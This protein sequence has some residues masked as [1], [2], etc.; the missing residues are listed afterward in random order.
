MQV[1][2]HMVELSQ[3]QVARVAGIL[4]L[5]IIIAGI[6][7][8]FFVRS[9]LIV[10]GDAMATANKVLASEGLFR[11]SIAADLVMIM[12]DVA[13]AV[14]FYVLLKPVSRSLSLLAAFFRLAQAANLGINALNLFFGLQLLH[15]AGDVAA[16]SVDQLHDLALFF[17]NAHGVGYTISLVFFGFSILILG[18]LI[19]KSGYLPRIL[20]ILLIIASLGYLLDGFANVLLINYADYA[21]ILGAVVFGPALIAELTVALWLLI[22]G[23]KD[24]SS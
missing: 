15:G 6:W 21:D 9:N 24:E 23:V 1:K 8:F 13:L 11:A 18:Y 19:F 17:F 10:P 22:K 2:R 3:R 4:Y 7:A 14:A 5:I 16:F 12:S 20:G